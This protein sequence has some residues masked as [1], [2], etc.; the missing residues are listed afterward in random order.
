M[1]LCLK[2]IWSLNREHFWIYPCIDIHY[3]N[4]KK[5]G[6]QEICV[7]GTVRIDP[8]ICKVKL[9]KKHK[10]GNPSKFQHLEPT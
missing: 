1:R 7:R 9:W 5:I 8:L 4:L 2:I 6:L 3:P 10:K